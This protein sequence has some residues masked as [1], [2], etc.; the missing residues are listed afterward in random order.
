MEEMNRQGKRAQI[1]RAA[2]G[3]FSQ[4][5]FHKAKIEEIAKEAGIGKGTVYEYFSSKK[6]L[7][8]EM[9]EE[10]LSQYIDL[11]LNETAA[12][13]DYVQKLEKIVDVNIY[14][15]TVHRDLAKVILSD[16]G[17][18]G[19]NLKKWMMATKV[20]IKEVVE[21]IILSGRERGAFRKVDPTMAAQVFLGA[22]GSI[23]GGLLFFENPVD[24]ETLKH[25]KNQLMDIILRGIGA[26]Q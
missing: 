5:G 1:L 8:K 9:I 18:I 14:F 3:V 19:E 12:A 16:P 17:G 15:A 7:F 22:I 10:S 26:G 23:I 2:A 21:D 24:P 11:A 4:H 13:D 25:H 6:E 20:R